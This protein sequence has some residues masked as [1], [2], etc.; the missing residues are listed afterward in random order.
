MIPD[1]AKAV[2]KK[3][4]S[5]FRRQKLVIGSIIAMPLLL[6]ILIPL[7]MFAPIAM[8]APEG[9]TWDV[10]NLFTQGRLDPA[11]DMPE[12]VSTLES[13]ETADMALQNTRVVNATIERAVL[14]EC[15][16]RDSTLKNATIDSCLLENVDLYN[17]VVTNSK[18]AGLNGETIMSVDSELVFEHERESELEKLIPTFLNM[19]LILFIILPVTLPTIIASY[20]IVGEKNNKSLE[21]I[22]AS[23][24]TDGELLLGKV[25]SA[26]VPSMASTL[27]AVVVGGAIINVF[28][29]QLGEPLL[30][31]LTWA[32]GVLLLAPLAC[33]MSI[34]ACVIVSSRVT[35][36]RA[37]QQVGGFIVMPVI[38][39]MF[40]VLAGVIL[41]TP[42]AMLAI[43]GAFAAADGGLYY[44]AKAIFNREDILVRWA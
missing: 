4:L 12:T 31:N 19:T 27:G 14:A 17:C 33:V 30:P 20:S 3:D 5:E 26:F 13:V 1:N 32:L 39:L 24:T 35:D 10:E 29:S 21:P 7:S 23:P 22:L 6:G 37:A 25:L 34:L 28:L 43:S 15:D 41:L 38:V 42:L 18:G 11:W 44:F 40:G 36:V 8:E 2:M 16:V 9:P